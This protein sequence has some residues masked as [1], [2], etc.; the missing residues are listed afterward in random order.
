MGND[1]EGTGKWYVKYD[2]GTCVK[3]CTGAFESGGIAE[4]WQELFK[5]KNTCC[6]KKI[7]YNNKCP[8]S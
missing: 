7:K 8:V 2:E 4:S 1:V 3:D 6:E 5:D